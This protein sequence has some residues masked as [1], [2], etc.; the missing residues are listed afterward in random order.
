[1][2]YPAT[3]EEVPSQRSRHIIH[4]YYHDG[5]SITTVLLFSSITETSMLS[6]LSHFLLTLI[7]H[8]DK[9]DR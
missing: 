6:F 5:R 3:V 8:N 2:V 9:T 1:M 4:D 7:T